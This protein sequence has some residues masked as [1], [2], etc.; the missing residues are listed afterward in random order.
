MAEVFTDIQKLMLQ[1]LYYK[2]RINV[3]HYITT[4]YDK[5]VSSTSNSRIIWRNLYNLFLMDMIEYKDGG[6]IED[7]FNDFYPNKDMQLTKYGKEVMTTIF[8]PTN[9]MG[10]S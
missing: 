5:G 3:N 1:S 4:F 8:A 10:K 2:N 9:I 6:K 7:Y